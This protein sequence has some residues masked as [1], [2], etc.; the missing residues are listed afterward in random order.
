M[1]QLQQLL[2]LL[3]SLQPIAWTHPMARSVDRSA[4]W[5]GEMTDHEM[6][7]MQFWMAVGLAIWVCLCGF[8]SL[9]LGLYFFRKWGRETALGLPAATAP[10]PNIFLNYNTANEKLSGRSQAESGA[11]TRPL[12]KQDAAEKSA[13]P[14][15]E[16]EH[17]E[18][19]KPRKSG[20]KESK[21]RSPV[22]PAAAAKKTAPLPRVAKT[23]PHKTIFRAAE[24]PPPTWEGSQD[25]PCF[26]KTA[27]PLPATGYGS[28]QDKEEPHVPNASKELPKENR[29]PA[30]DQA[31]TKANRTQSSKGSRKRGTSSYK[32]P[33]N[34]M[35]NVPNDDITQTSQSHHRSY[36]PLR[37]APTIEV[38]PT[39]SQENAQQNGDGMAPAMLTNE[40]PNEPQK[41][42]EP[43]LPPQSAYMPVAAADLAAG[44]VHSMYMPAAKKT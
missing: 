41:D 12:Q 5:P 13:E 8:V 31:E 18:P 43:Q 1:R 16:K 44:G 14:P 23:A 34:K 35:R 19:D 26:P 2:L 30:L 25:V 22:T 39:G 29:D 11:S 28:P 38:A 24:L 9:C 27:A 40:Q 36:V 37:L 17:H 21:P 3:G 32:P 7:A 15:S 6:L 4:D 33:V 10:I 42:E 20:S